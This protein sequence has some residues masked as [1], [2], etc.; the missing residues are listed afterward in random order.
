[1]KTYSG[2]RLS[3]NCW[4][5]LKLYKQKGQDYTKTIEEAVELY[6]KAKD[7]EERCL[8]TKNT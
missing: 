2:F 1:M 7:S 4:E 6:V 3:S 5:I 8:N